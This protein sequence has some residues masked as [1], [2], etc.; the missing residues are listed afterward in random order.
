MIAFAWAPE[1]VGFFVP[2]DPQVIAEGARFIR[3]TCLT[4]GGIGVQ[5]CVVAA[6]R[7]SGDML[8]AMLVALLSQFVFQFPIAYILSRWTDLSTAGL[9]WSFPVTNVVVATGSAVWFAL[10][11]WRDVRQK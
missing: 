9:W 11:G 8:T 5:L 2:R 10:D 1:L 4:W 3:I 6:F 7:A